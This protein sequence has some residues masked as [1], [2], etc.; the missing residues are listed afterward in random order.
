MVQ[1][2]LHLDH[3]RSRLWCVCMSVCGCGG[4]QGC[5][6]VCDDFLP[7]AFENSNTSLYSWLADK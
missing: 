2:T 3:W 5:V 6:R 7:P 4:A 1:M